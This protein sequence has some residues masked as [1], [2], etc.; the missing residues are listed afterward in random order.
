MT[1]TEKK[2]FLQ[3]LKHFFRN[4]YTKDVAE[5]MCERLDKAKKNADVLEQ[6]Y[7]LHQQQWQQFR[8]AFMNLALS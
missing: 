4:C 6:I 2:L 7:N 1:E 8:Q 5:E 3:N